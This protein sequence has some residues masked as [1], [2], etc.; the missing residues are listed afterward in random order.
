MASIYSSVDTSSIRSAISSATCDNTANNRIIGEI[1]RKVGNS[2]VLSAKLTS[3]LRSAIS[4][5]SSS[6][7]NGSIS[8]ASKYLN[9]LSTVCSYID[10]I[11]A[12]ERSNSSLQTRL[13]YDEPYYYEETVDGFETVITPKGKKLVKPV[14]NVVTRTGYRRVLDTGVQ[15]QISDNNASIKNYENLIASLL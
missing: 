8:T 3:P 7:L 4:N 13:Y 9:D 12:L 14:S 5:L 15:K 2:D 6:S 11:K 1:G 10:S